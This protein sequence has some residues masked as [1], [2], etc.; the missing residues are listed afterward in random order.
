MSG[1]R[2]AVGDF[3]MPDLKIPERR[4]EDADFPAQWAADH[5]RTL[6]DEARVIL[7]RTVAEVEALPGGRGS[8]SSTMDVDEPRNA[9]EASQSRGAAS[10][11]PMTLSVEDAA[12]MQ[13]AWEKG[14][15]RPKIAI[16][17]LP[18]YEG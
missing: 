18:R 1:R 17:P 7:Q 5:G 2:Y 10:L 14:L 16:T 11:Q 6:E 4:S 8:T 15:A 3:E 13:D 12:Q 9:G